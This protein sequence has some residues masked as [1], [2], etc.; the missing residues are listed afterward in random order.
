MEKRE[1]IKK[2]AKLVTEKEKFKKLFVQF[3]G[4]LCRLLLVIIVEEKVKFSAK[5]VVSVAVMDDIKK[6]W[7]KK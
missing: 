2:L 4:L 5:N 7:W 3:W 6:M 1:V